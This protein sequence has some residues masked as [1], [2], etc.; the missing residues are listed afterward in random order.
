MHHTAVEGATWVW[1]HHTD[2]FCSQWH[3][4]LESPP[5]QRC[6]TAKS[7]QARGTR[8]LSVGVTEM[9]YSSLLCAVRRGET[10]GDDV[11]STLK[12]KSG[13]GAPS[14]VLTCPRVPSP[15]GAAPSRASVPFPRECFAVA[16]L[17][18][19]CPCAFP[20]LQPAGNETAACELCS[21]SVPGRTSASESCWW[22]ERP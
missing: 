12:L 5:K 2:G 10:R 13:F 18:A 21:V 16:L 14:G 22:A 20:L 19:L 1:G 6:P 4:V 17:S 9:E 15:Y 3:C 11:G 7:Q 8:R